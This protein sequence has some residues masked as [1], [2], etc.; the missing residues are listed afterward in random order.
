MSQTDAIIDH[1]ADMQRQVYALQSQ[2]LW[3]SASLILLY[4]A[5]YLLSRE[6]TA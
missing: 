3:L 2:I 6:G 4:V 5:G 1:A